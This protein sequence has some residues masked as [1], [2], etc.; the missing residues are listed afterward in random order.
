MARNID[1]ESPIQRSGFQYL[2]AKYPRALIFSVPNELASKVGGGVDGRKRQQMIRNIQANAK[3]MGM[4]PG[5]GDLC[6]LLNGRFFVF[7]FKAKGNY[8][9]AN[10]KAAEALV[11]ANG[12]YYFVVRSID[13]IQ[14]ALDRVLLVTDIPHRGKIG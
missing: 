10:Q 4:L 12:G 13:D 5:M 6:M 11:D 2:K 8:Q 1:R 7:E 3:K 14:E 9:Q